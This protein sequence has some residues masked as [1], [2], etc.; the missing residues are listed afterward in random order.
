MES[1]R[2]DYQHDRNQEIPLR[3]Q[4]FTERFNTFLHQRRE[5]ALRG[6]D[7]NSNNALSAGRA[8]LIDHVVWKTFWRDFM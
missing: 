6:E 4:L 1:L 3:P 5:E 2:W 8:E 7:L